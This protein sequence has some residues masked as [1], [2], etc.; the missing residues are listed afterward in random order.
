MREAYQDILNTIKEQQGEM[1][2]LLMQWTDINSHSENCSGL[3]N[4]L[5]ALKTSFQTLNAEMQQIAIPPRKTINTQGEEILI[6]LGDC[7]LLRKHPEAPLQIFLGGHMD[8]VYPLSSP[9]QKAVRVDETTLNG[10]GAADMKGGLIVIFKAL[11]AF[12]S[13]PGAGKVG[14]TVL[15]NSDE[16]LGSPGSRFLLKQYAAQNHLGLIFEPAYPDGAFVSS[17]KGSANFTLFAKGKAAHAGRDFYAGRN[18]ISALANFIVR[19]EKLINREKGVTI[20]IGH[21]HGGGPVNIIPEMALCKINLRA[22]DTKDFEE[23]IRSMERFVEEGNQAEGIALTLHRDA[24]TPPKPFDHPIQALFQALET[25]C[26]DLGF[27]MESK[28]SGGTCDGSRLY[29][30][31]MPNIDTMGVVGGAIHTHD[32]YVH[33]PSLY[34]RAQLTTL[35]LMRLANKEITYD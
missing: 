26:R 32:E 31:G 10:P 34:Q 21:I 30:E 17:R 22:L 8:T 33:L 9:F 35:F 6:P 18:A 12:E 20:N 25:C 4:M 23:A 3:A 24:E 2:S 16:E 15:I 1:V 7:L 29:A 28:P 14:W 11:Q 27:K 13:S 19:A 5:N